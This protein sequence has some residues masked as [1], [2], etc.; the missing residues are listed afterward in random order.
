VDIAL[1][2]EVWQLLPDKAVYWKEQRLLIV[3]DL[4]LAKDM[5]F[6]KH[7]MAVPSGMTGKTLERLGSIINQF[8]PERI[9]LLGDLFHSEFNHAVEEFATWKNSRS[10][11]RFQLV[12]G[13]HDILHESEYDRMGIEL[14]GNEYALGPFT[15]RHEPPDKACETFTVCGHLHPAARLTGTGRQSLRFPC[16]WQTENMFVLPAFGEFTGGKTIQP[17]HGDSVYAVAEGSL[18]KLK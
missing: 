17:A 12:D 11:V 14:L 16:F 18:Y 6:R 3:S 7:G 2:G 9:L 5:H 1:K 13:N 10:A 8:Q 4:H 15:F